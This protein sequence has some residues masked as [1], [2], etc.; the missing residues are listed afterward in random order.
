MEQPIF[1]KYRR[2]ENSLEIIEPQQGEYMLTTVQDRRVRVYGLLSTR[3]IRYELA[4]IPWIP[5]SMYCKI[6]TVMKFLKPL[7]ESH[8]VYAFKN[9][10]YVKIRR[11]QSN[12]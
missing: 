9:S 12:D 5:Y 6:T 10:L 2:N 4:I 8:Q 11:S 1:L 3:R 7:T